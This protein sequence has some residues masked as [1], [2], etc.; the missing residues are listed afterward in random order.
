[1]DLLA[2]AASLGQNVLIGLCTDAFANGR[3][4]RRVTPFDRRKG[5]LMEHMGQHH[6]DTRVTIEPIDDDYGPARHGEYDTIVVS[7]AT[8]TTAMR[9][10]RERKGDGLSQLDIVVVPHRLAQD[11]RPISSTRVVEGEI[12][13]EGRMLRTLRVAIGSANR[14]KVEA[15]RRICEQLYE[16]VDCYSCPVDSGVAEQPRGVDETVTGA[17]NRARAALGE[18]DENEKEEDGVEHD[19][20]VGIEAGLLPSP[21]EDQWM[22]VQY[23]AVVDRTGRVTL[24]HG[25]GF[26]YPP[27]VIEAVDS[28]QTVGEAMTQLTGIQ[29]IGQKGGAIGHL[30]RDLLRR[31]SLTE[32]AVL[33]AFI[34][35]IRQE[36]YR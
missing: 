8:R 9:L 6:A 7:E 19:L 28:G 25:S 18:V 34:P 14:V 35:R 32:Q 1:M 16:Y 36:L 31:R 11:G 29:D 2:R 26:A 3:R 33:M 10:N 23:C 22:D 27:S 15:V 13:P 21:H 5:T 30:T 20:G 4:E 17:I 12:D 24:G